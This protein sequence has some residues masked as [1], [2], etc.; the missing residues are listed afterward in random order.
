MKIVKILFYC[1]LLCFTAF[2]VFA[3]FP[4]HLVYLD[5]ELKD[6]F[7]NKIF[8]TGDSLRASQVVNFKGNL[9]L[10]F[11]ASQKEL[12]KIRF[13]QRKEMN[14]TDIEKVHFSTYKCCISSFQSF[15]THNE[16]PYPLLNTDTELAFDNVLRHKYNL[17]D[18]NV[19]AFM[20]DGKGKEK[21]KKSPLNGQGNAIL[22]T[23]ILEIIHQEIP[24][25]TSQVI[26]F[27][28]YR[29]DNPDESE[30]L[31]EREILKIDS[32][33]LKRQ[34]ST[35]LFLLKRKYGTSNKSS[36]ELI[37]EMLSKCIFELYGFPD[38]ANL[39][40]WIFDNFNINLSYS[41]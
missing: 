33:K 41:K 21:M 11:D 17:A 26:A 13:S 23:K 1:L 35:L 19:L 6:A 25:S 24:I 32:T 7:T 39:Q 20:Y 22:L 36:K 37:I 18:K 38:E 27:Y 2:D 10:I 16:K 15:I 14:I 34:V 12:R 4:Y 8:K 9:A 29:A 5:G 30:E 40:K 3:Q 28:A 31:V